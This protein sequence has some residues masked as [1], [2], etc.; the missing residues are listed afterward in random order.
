MCI[1][2]NMICWIDE[3][4]SCTLRVGSSA[5]V[6][7]ICWT[8]GLRAC[9]WRS[10]L[11]L[12]EWRALMNLLC[13]TRWCW[14]LLS[15]RS[16][17][18][19]VVDCGGQCTMPKMMQCICKTV[20]PIWWIIDVQTCYGKVLDNGC[21]FRLGSIGCGLSWGPARGVGIG[22]D[23]CLSLC[24]VVEAAAEAVGIAVSVWGA[25]TL[26]SATVFWFH[27]GIP[28][29][30]IGCL[31]GP[32]KGVQ[33]MVASHEGTSVLWACHLVGPAKVHCWFMQSSMLLLS[34]RMMM[35]GKALGY[36]EGKWA[37]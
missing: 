3:Q 26:R 6:W 13:R 8:C 2:C 22:D 29:N 35:V 20:V 10:R 5:I 16:Y 31:C 21:S 19:L 33:A 25:D 9:H 32:C 36:I 7:K 12:G 28:G 11:D 37:V 17:H 24:A 23:Q 15:K 1:G 27:S 18:W 30:A 4:G 14:W 34:Q